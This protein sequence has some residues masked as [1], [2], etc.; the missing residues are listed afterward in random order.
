[1]DGEEGKGGKAGKGG[2]GVKGGKGRMGGKGV[3][4]AGP[5]KDGQAGEQDGKGKRG[6]GGG[7]GKGGGAAKRP[8]E[9][10][11][12]KNKEPRGDTPPYCNAASRFETH[13]YGVLASWAASSLSLSH[14]Y[15]MVCLSVFFLAIVNQ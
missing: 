8:E 13:R 12:A 11:K 14:F 9:L 6:E 10:K 2:K 3:K 15:H 7:D 4:G 1:M 5:L